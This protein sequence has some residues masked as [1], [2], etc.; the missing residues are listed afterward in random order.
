[1]ELLLLL[2]HWWLQVWPN[3]IVA[4]PGFLWHHRRVM[5]HIEELMK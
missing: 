1:M 3:M 4:V 5:K 2:W